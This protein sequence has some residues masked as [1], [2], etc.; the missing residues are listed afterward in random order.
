MPRNSVDGHIVP[1]IRII[2]TQIAIARN[3]KHAISPYFIASLFFAYTLLFWNFLYK[4]IAISM[5]IKSTK[6]P[7]ALKYVSEGI[8]VLVPPESVII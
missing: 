8:V 1:K 4:K 5:N 6:S 3:T 2:V 7:V